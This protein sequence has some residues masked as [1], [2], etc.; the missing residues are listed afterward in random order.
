MLAL[1]TAAFYFAAAFA[2]LE[3]SS[4]ATAVGAAFML[5]IGI[6]IVDAAAHALAPDLA[7]PALVV[8]LTICAFLLTQLIARALY[9]LAGRQALIMSVFM[10]V[11]YLLGNAFLRWAFGRG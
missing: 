6:E 10:A 7:Q 2:E 8:L 11:A 3:D 1:T 9:Q 5:V 4:L